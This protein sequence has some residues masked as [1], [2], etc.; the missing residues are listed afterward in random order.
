MFVAVEDAGLGLYF[1][2]GV[3]ELVAGGAGAYGFAVPAGAEGVGFFVL[4][5]VH[6]A[7]FGEAVGEFGLFNFVVVVDEAGA[8]VLRGFVEAV[9]IGDGTFEG[10]GVGVV[11][12]RRE[13]V[14]VPAEINVEGWDEHLEEV[15]DEELHEAR[16]FGYQVV[17]GEGCGGGVKPVDA[18]H[19]LDE[20]ALSDHGTYQVQSERGGIVPV[21]R[22]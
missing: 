17:D 2:A 3:F 8:E 22:Q 19:F 20:G 7:R 4:S 12:G 11:A 16:V 10:G 6:V 18:L 14:R 21:A 9:I 13:L 15:F 5:L 1:F